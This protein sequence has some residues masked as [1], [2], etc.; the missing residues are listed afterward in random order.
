MSKI[1]GYEYMPEYKK[2]DIMNTVA[3]KAFGRTLLL[4]EKS[5]LKEF[6]IALDVW[7]EAIS[8]DIPAYEP[9]KLHP[10]VKTVKDFKATSLSET[11]AEVYEYDDD[12]LRLFVKAAAC[13]LDVE[14]CDD[15][16]DVIAFN[17]FEDFYILEDDD[18]RAVAEAFG[19]SLHPSFAENVELFK[20]TGLIISAGKVWKSLNAS[21]FDIDGNAYIT[22]DTT[23]R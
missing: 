17:A 21:K 2:L 13:L 15:M 22:I 16:V 20:E 3:Y 10:T 8:N 4:H 7:G 19:L 11:G 1:N 14:L 12:T 9:I 6:D 5:A 23:R 18:A